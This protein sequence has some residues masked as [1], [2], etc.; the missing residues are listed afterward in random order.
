MDNGNSCQSAAAISIINPTDIFYTGQ[1][2]V[3][4]FI[5]IMPISLPNP[6]FDDLLES[7][8]RDDSNKWSNIGFGK[9]RMELAYIEVDFMHLISIISP[10]DI[11]YSVACFSNTNFLTN[12]PKSMLS[13]F[14]GIVSSRRFQRMVTT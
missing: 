7:S 3:P 4:I 12:Q 5:S 13:P 9:K 1:D 11:F 2:K 8:H 10:T 14:I 6:M